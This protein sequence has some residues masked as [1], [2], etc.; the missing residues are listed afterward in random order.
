MLCLQVAE[1][2]E[3]GIGALTDD[4]DADN[5]GVEDDDEDDDEDDEAE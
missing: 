2:K 4:D 1:V 3:E 5:E